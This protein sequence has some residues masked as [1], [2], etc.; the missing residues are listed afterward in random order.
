MAKLTLHVE[1]LEVESF[2]T[3]HADS[4]KGTVFG[5]A[6]D[7][8]G[9]CAGHYTCDATCDQ[10]CGVPASCQLVNGYCGTY[11]EVGCPPSYWMCTVDTDARGACS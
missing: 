11:A 8:D 3:A 7:A 5:H 1:Q 2:E 10:S 6:T 4:A 9:T